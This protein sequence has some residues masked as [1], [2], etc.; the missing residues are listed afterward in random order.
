MKKM[1][2]SVFVWST[3]VWFWLISV[4]VGAPSEKTI[5]PDE[6]GTT[7]AVEYPY[8]PSRQYAFVWRNWTV[9]PE[10]RLAEV[11]DTDV[12]HVRRLAS[13]MGLPPQQKIEPQW[14]T[15]WG[16]ITVLRRNWHL[17]PYDQLLT[18]LGISKEELAWRLIEDDFLF[19]KLGYKKP[20]CRPLHY[21]EPTDEMVRQAAEL[22]KIVRKEFGKGHE[23]PRFAFME[24]FAEPIVE[25]TST[26]DGVQSDDFALRLIYPYCAAFGDPL[27]DPELSS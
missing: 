7:P 1:N 27:M 10:R 20:Y 3:V 22:K 18:L 24:E 4:A 5:L 8:F 14:S 11:L 2:L 16:Y 23:V 13:S 9:V 21:E 12:E 17:L 25:V 26:T 15:S 6:Q 19:V